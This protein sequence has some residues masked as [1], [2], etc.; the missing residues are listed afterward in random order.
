LPDETPAATSD[1]AIVS[2]DIVGHSSASLR[3][4]LARVIALNKIVADLIEAH[5]DNQITWASGGDGGHVMLGQPTWCT[6]AIDLIAR[7]RH[8]SAESR[9][10]LRVTAHVGPVAEIRGA[11]GRVQ[12]VGD[13]INAAGWML[14]R[15]SSEGVVVSQAFHD[16][17]RQAHPSRSMVFHDS[18]VLRDKNLTA[19]CLMLLS[20]EEDRSYWAAPTEAGREELVRALE[21]GTGWD[22][23]YYAK[24]ILQ[25][26]S[27][28]AQAA[29]AITKLGPLQLSYQPHH[30]KASGAGIPRVTNPYLGYLE[31]SQL[32]EV[33][34]LG[35][36]IERRYNDVI[37]RRGDEGDTMFVILRGEV[38][39]YKPEGQES[40]SS[41]EPA[42]THRE[43]E[44]VG[45]LAF[46]L[47]RQRTADLIALD[48][49]ALLSFNYHDISTKLPDTRPGRLVKERVSQFIAS[50]AL[51]HICHG[52]PYLL[53][54]ER[55]GPLAVGSQSWQDALESLEDDTRLIS[56]TQH[57]LNL[58][59]EDLKAGDGTSSGHGIYIL[60]AGQLR[61]GTARV[62]GS[63]AL[64][65]R[66]KSDSFPLLWADIP[67]VLVLPKLSFDVEAEPVKVLYIAADGLANL[68]PPKREAVYSELRRAAAQCYH[69]DAFISYNSLDEPAARRWEAALREKGLE[70]YIDT[71]NSGNEFPTQLRTALLDSRA[72]VALISPS[73]MVRES[74]ENWVARETNFHREYFDLARVF[75]VCLPGGHHEEIV[76]GFPAIY[77]GNDEAAAIDRV[78]V[79]LMRLRDGHEDPPYSLRDKNELLLS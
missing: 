32:R 42:F 67:G 64:V 33:V 31:S 57:K 23:L 70:V 17:L 66:I 63:T 62:S 69:F 3:D 19:Q 28:D 39:V 24:R 68:E 41:S 78:A 72:V 54:H 43:G 60:A 9:T 20:I 77:V 44:I 40:Q 13:G 73:V 10:P 1:V 18:R 29:R 65:K 21:Q 50:R 35:Q 15:A 22:A 45:E 74:S 55:T 4:Q 76:P 49:V 6:D 36:L 59:F 16:A 46:A 7:F 34:Q 52:A 75:P 37:C 51:E 27:V 71:P 30:E 48:D 47:G 61:C 56:V 38:G 26:N 53:G 25:T 58:S 11:D 79:E 5:G 2:C 8:W 14:T 12:V